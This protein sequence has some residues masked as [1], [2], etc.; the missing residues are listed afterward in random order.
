M[1]GKKNPRAPMLLPSYR[2]W[3]W[4]PPAAPRCSPPSSRSCW[5][6]RRGRGSRSGA[7]RGQGA[8]E[9]SG[10]GIRIGS[11]IGSGAPPRRW[12]R[13][14]RHPRRR[15]T[16]RATA[17]GCGAAPGGTCPGAVPAG[18]GSRSVAPCPARA[19]R[20][21]RRRP[22]PEQGGPGS[23]ESPEGEPARAGQGRARRP[24]ASHRWFLQH[25]SRPASVPGH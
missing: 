19:P 13:L 18:Q 5:E 2:L 22:R 12:R 10:I 17:W 4:P 25:L 1:G 16:G 6:P 14:P 15:G 9:R 24:A 8:A 11:G 20:G 3:S 23:G 7:E 21:G